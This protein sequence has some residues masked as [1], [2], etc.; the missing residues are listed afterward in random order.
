MTFIHKIKLEL[1]GT[2]VIALPAVCGIVDVQV[3]NG[4]IVM[5]Y[6]WDEIFQGR[7][8]KDVVEILMYGTGNPIDTLIRKR[9]LATVQLNGF[10]WH[11]YL[12]EA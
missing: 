7:N 11:I 4:E 1:C 8:K 2:Q 5:W 12:K 6:S 9:H 10:V 3:Q